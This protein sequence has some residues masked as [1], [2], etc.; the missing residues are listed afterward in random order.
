MRDEK[1]VQREIESERTDREPSAEYQLSVIRKVKKKKQRKEK[2]NSGK[3][4]KGDDDGEKNQLGKFWYSNDGAIAA[5]AHLHFIFHLLTP[6][7]NNNN[8]KST[9]PQTLIHTEKS[10]QYKRVIDIC[11]FTR[12]KLF[13][14]DL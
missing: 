5:V 11:I 1:V 12:V 14:N 13:R 8:N 10:I 6:F 2:R 7:N 9:T 3:G 4:K